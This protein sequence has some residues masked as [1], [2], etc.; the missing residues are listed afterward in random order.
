MRTEFLSISVLGVA[1]G[2]R[3]K[4][5]GCKSALNP[6][7]FILLT[8]LR[9]G[10]GVSITLCCFVFLCFSVLLALRLP[11]L[12]NSTDSRTQFLLTLASERYTIYFDIGRKPEHVCM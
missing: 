7:W 3:V 5:T 2:P 8:V 9:G 1:S 10:P 11:R 6:W 12:G 4:L